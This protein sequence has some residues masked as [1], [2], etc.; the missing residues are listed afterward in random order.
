MFGKPFFKRK[1]RI[2]FDDS[3]FYKNPALHKNFIF[4][5][6][7]VVCGVISNGYQGFEE[8]YQRFFLYHLF[9]ALSGFEPLSVLAEKPYFPPLPQ[10]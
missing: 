4:L 6:N 10:P 3:G 2:L 1:Q 8:E 7:K 5:N 9:Y